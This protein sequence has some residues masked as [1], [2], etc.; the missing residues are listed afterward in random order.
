MQD[1]L[2]I[3]PSPA[4][5]RDKGSKPSLGQSA[6]LKQERIQ[7]RDRQAPHPPGVGRELRVTGV[8]GRTGH[9]GT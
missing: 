2:A 8:H 9:I 1:Q 4:G 3:T 5:L 7:A 6:G